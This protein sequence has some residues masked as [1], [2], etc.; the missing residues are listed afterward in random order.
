MQSRDDALKQLLQ[1]GDYLLDLKRPTDALQE[2]SRALAIA[3]EDYEVLCQLARAHAMLGDSERAIDF[4]QKAI[5]ADPNHQWAFRIKAHVHLLQGQL[6]SAY[7]AATTA[8]YLE[9]EN[10][11]CLNMLANCAL[12]RQ[13]L[14]EAKMI[15]EML[16]KQAPESTYG[17]AILAEVARVRDELPDAA[18]H[19]EKVLSLDPNDAHSLE[20]L[21]SIRNAH[22]KYGESVSLLRGALSVDPNPELRRNSFKDSMN[23]F[24]LFGQANERRK[25]VAGLLVMVFIGYLFLGIVLATYVKSWD[26]FTSYYLSGLGAIV[27]LGIPFLRRRFFASQSAQMQALYQNFSQQRRKRTLWA[28]AAVVGCAYGI[29]ALI[30]LDVGDATIFAFPF[31]I[32]VT[33]LWVYML[34]ITVRLVLLWTSDTWTR[35]IGSD[36][37][38]DQR[39]LSVSAVALP[40]ITFGVLVTVILTDSGVAGVFFLIGSA[41]TAIV[42]FRHYPTGTGVIMALL[43]AGLYAFDVITK[44]DGAELSSGVIG[45]VIGGIGIIGIFAQGFVRLQRYWQ[46]RRVSKIVGARELVEGGSKST[47]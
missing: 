41:L 5:A 40:V 18:Q 35:L 19:Y 23:R 17:H 39:K 44:A 33:A 47:R 31:G 16:L 27:L 21:A 26:S 25:S 37:P 29:A 8:V 43:G 32:L 3:P 12:A 22:N 15:A 24:A 46:R 20:S 30:Y 10:I 45:L 9:P 4:V 6:S 28:I 13:R 38:T 11:E 42:Y 2:F 1:R 14:E 36:V 34:A 7:K